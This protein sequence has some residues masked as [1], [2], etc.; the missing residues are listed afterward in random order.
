MNAT[1]MKLAIRVARFLKGRH[2]RMAQATI[3]AK[4]VLYLKEK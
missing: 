2:Q 1:M 4:L 3:V